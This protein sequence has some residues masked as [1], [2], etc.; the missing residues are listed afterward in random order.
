MVRSWPALARTEI[1][2]SGVADPSALEAIEH[3]VRSARA[4]GDAVTLD[5]RGLESCPP[6]FAVRR[7]DAHEAG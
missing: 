4:R 3:E 7:P 6:G 1:T 2:V 5:L